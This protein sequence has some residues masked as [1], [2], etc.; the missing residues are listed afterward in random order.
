MVVECSVSLARWIKN[1][2]FYYWTDSLIDTWK[3][4]KHVINNEVTF[5]LH[6]CQRFF[7]ALRQIKWKMHYTSSIPTKY[8]RSKSESENNSIWFISSKHICFH[9]NYF[10]FFHELTWFIKFM[11]SWNSKVD[12]VCYISK[13]R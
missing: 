3:K 8:S 6:L 11:S 7:F 1:N 4:K 5:Y 10:F 12:T 9:R 13:I 2:R